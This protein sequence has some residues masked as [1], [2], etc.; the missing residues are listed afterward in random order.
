[1]I[2]CCTEEESPGDGMVHNPLV[3]DP[4][5]FFKPPPSPKHPKEG[6][7]S[8]RCNF[9]CQKTRF[10]PPRGEN[11]KNRFFSPSRK[12]AFSLDPKREDSG[13]SIWRRWQLHSYNSFKKWRLHKLLST[14]PRQTTLLQQFIKKKKKI[15]KRKIHALLPLST[16]PHTPIILSLSLPLTSLFFFVVTEI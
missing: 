5:F 4:F 1:M 3:F 16:H 11:R 9:F 2:V 14:Q 8:L 7:V 15:E 6:T 10:S 13:A 12:F